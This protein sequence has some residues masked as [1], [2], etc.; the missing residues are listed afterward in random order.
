[1]INLFPYQKEAVRKLKPG[2]IL[3]GG[4][5]SG[6]SLTSLAYYRNYIFLNG[7]MPLYIITT[8][9]KRDTHEWD[10]ECSRVDIY[11]QIVDSWNNIGKYVNVC[12]A[13]FIF[14]EDKL[15]GKGAWV[16]IFYQIAKKNKWIVLTATPGD[17]WISYIPIFVANGFYKNRSEFLRR[18]VVFSPYVKFP[19]IQTYL[20]TDRLESLRKMIVVPMNYHREAIIHEEP[21]VCGYNSELY[22]KIVLT[23]WNFEKDVP[24]QNVSEYCQC[25]RKVVNSDSSRI[26]KIKDILRKHP[27]LIVFYNFDYELDML[28][29]LGKELGVYASELNG[30]KHIPINSK[31]SSWLH[32]VQYNSGCEAWNCIETNAICFYSLNYAWWMMTQSAGRIDRTNTPFSDLYY[33]FLYSNSHIDSMILSSLS[34]KETFNEKTMERCQF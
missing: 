31:C 4:V 24:I 34:K 7:E 5:G 20:E 17:N 33:Y 28:R 10:E 2:S 9:A 29:D 23:R 11:D 22:D 21:V 14:D 27:K 12:G 25:L 30:H 26:S 1:M 8:A 16:K 32:L 3:V 18:H 13:F 6:K 19:K 15:T